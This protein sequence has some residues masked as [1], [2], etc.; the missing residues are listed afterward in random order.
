MEDTF[1]FENRGGKLAELD[2]SFGNALGR[3]D[4]RVLLVKL[5][6]SFLEDFERLIIERLRLCDD[7]EHLNCLRQLSFFVR[8]Q[9]VG[10]VNKPRLRARVGRF[11]KWRPLG[12]LMAR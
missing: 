6:V 11:R 2:V 3:G 8:R 7:L 12:S 1:V 9:S 4:D 5:G 10:H